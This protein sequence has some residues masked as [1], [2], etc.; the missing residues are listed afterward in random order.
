MDIYIHFRER[1][2]R[3]ST[4]VI[5]RKHDGKNALEGIKP[6]I[7]GMIFER[8]TTAPRLLIIIR[9]MNEISNKNSL[10]YA[11]NTVC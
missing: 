1:T 2:C 7:P 3:F 11:Y 8:K 6:Q 10:F 4:G 5:M 9:I